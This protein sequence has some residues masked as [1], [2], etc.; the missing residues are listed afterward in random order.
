MSLPTCTVIVATYNCASTLAECLD[1]IVS[2]T[3]KP[4]L[5]V[6]DGG[7]TDNTKKI[8]QNYQKYISYYISEKD[9]GVY[10]AW[11]KALKK[12]NGE[13]IIFLGSD[14]WFDSN[15]S[16]HVALSYA[17]KTNGE[18]EWLIYPKVHLI[19]SNK[20]IT[21]VDNDEWEKV[22]GKFP[23]NM[24]VTHSGTL[25]K[26][27]IFKKYGFFDEKF[28]IAGDY[29]LF[30]RIFQDGVTA[31]FCSDY[32]VKMSIGGMSN[33][34]KQRVKLLSEQ[35]LVINRYGLKLSFKQ[36]FWKKFKKIA[37]KTMSLGKSK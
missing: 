8:I 9:Q 7:S 4:E 1:S 13:W 34:P 5:I 12:S 35:L 2:Q 30:S 16:L 23:E 21:G 6:I 31:K 24:P 15:T 27:V 33:A 29:E 37:Y 3:V 32:I 19:D 10:D 36:V 22:K 28:R 18:K 25:H 17:S 20:E 26:N 11:N 14:D